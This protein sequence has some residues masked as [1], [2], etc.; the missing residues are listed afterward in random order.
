MFRADTGSSGVQKLGLFGMG[1]V[2]KTT[3]SKALCNFFQQ[4]YFGRVCHVELGNEKALVLQKKVLKELARL[5]EAEL[6]QIIDCDR[7]T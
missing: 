1:G 6:H 5:P 7:V 4:D 2:G 3:V